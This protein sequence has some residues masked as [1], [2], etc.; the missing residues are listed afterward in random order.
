MQRRGKIKLQWILPEVILLSEQERSFLDSRMCLSGYDNLCVMKRRFYYAY[1][2]SSTARSVLSQFE[3][4]IGVCRNRKP[5]R[6]LKLLFQYLLART[7]GR[8]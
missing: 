6:F 7:T 4:S 5:S 3:T 1:F 2:K 8:N